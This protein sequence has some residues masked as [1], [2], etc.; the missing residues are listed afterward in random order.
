[1]LR[2]GLKEG[3][4]LFSLQERVPPCLGLV[5]MWVLADGAGFS[6]CLGCQCCSPTRNPLGFL[7]W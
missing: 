1:M 3:L 2:P 7:V 6:C 4:W 5:E